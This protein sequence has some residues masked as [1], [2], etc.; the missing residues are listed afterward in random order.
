MPKIFK[1]NESVLDIGIFYT[2]SVRKYRILY[3]YTKCKKTLAY[4]EKTG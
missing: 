1:K 3:K 2:F 4:S